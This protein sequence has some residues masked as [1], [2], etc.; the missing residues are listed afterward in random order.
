MRA[1][2][3]ECAFM[4]SLRMEYS[5]YYFIIAFVRIAQLSYHFHHVFHRLQHIVCIP[6]L[7]FKFVIVHR[8]AFVT[9]DY[10]LCKHML[11][12]FMAIIAQL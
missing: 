3:F 7:I 9:H 1:R 5:G 10:G 12:T 4:R 11:L 6:I 2:V 8:D